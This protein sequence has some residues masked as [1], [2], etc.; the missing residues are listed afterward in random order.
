MQVQKVHN[1]YYNANFGASLTIYNNIKKMES[2]V[3]DFLETEFPKK[4]E[5][6]KR[7]I[8]VYLNGTDKGVFYPDTIRYNNGKKYSDAIRVELELSESKETLLD[9]LL[10]SI[11]GFVIREKA[12]HKI[13]ELKKDIIKVA[14]EAYKDSEYEFKKSFDSWYHPRRDMV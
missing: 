6:I 8:D 3:I 10:N 14:D 4:T 11:N 2:P 13:E 1:N 12:L 7:H 5:N 9:K